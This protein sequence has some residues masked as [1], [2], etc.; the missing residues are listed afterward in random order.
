[1]PL[2][3]PIGDGTYGAKRGRARGARGGRR[4]RRPPRWAHA[5]TR[6]DAPCHD[7]GHALP[8]EHGR[9]RELL[10]G[11]ARRSGTRTW[12]V[13]TTTTAPATHPAT[14]THRDLGRDLEDGGELHRAERVGGVERGGAREVGRDGGPATPL[15]A[16]GHRRLRERRG[17][18][19]ARR[20]SRHRA[21]GDVREHDRDR[22]R[23]EST[24]QASSKT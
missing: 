12:S 3:S 17:P 6:G 10:V 7:L 19:S 24:G 4:G 8:H 16:R 2:P 9:R 20:R 22:E 13:R 23:R 18:W 21:R 11:S 14:R 15:P 1:M 5:S